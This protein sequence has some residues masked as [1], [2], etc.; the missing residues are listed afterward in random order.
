MKMAYIIVRIFGFKSHK[1]ELD[2]TR[3]AKQGFKK[4]R[5]FKKL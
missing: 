4:P 2:Q 3:A 1:L 5:F